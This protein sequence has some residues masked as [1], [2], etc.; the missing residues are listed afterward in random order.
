MLLKITKMSD[1]LKKAIEYKGFASSHDIIS[2]IW[3]R[4]ARS[5]ELGILSCDDDG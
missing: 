1:V 5:S 4:F 2:I 3:P